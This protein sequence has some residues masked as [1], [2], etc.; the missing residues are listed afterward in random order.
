MTRPALA[1]AVLALLLLAPACRRSPAPQA[2]ASPTPGASP[3]DVV[4]QVDGVAIRAGELDQRVA[5]RLMRVRQEEYEIRRQA[6]EE[7]IGERLLEKE[8]RAR[9][10]S[11]FVFM[12]RRPP[13]S[14][15][16][17]YT[18]RESSSSALS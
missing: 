1:R 4:A 9:F 17:P 16:F 2:T 7:M 3:S 6:L 12:I 5:K 18:T 11:N 8:A 10:I 14:T 13:R 15:L